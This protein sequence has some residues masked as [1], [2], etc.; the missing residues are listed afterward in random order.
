M[1]CALIGFQT[2]ARALQIKRQQLMQP[3]AGY[4]IPYMV[5]I[6]AGPGNHLCKRRAVQA[7]RPCAQ[8]ALLAGG[9][10]VH[11]VFPAYIPQCKGQ[12]AGFILQRARK[13]IIRVA[14]AQQVHKFRQQQ[15]IR[16]FTLRGHNLR[17]IIG[18]RLIP[19]DGVLIEVGKHLRSL[20]PDLR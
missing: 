1:P 17:Q 4:I 14:V 5:G 18:I 11:A 10:R 6:A 2:V 13:L 19:V 12:I 9:S 16:P 15:M 3:I 7:Q 20:L 8:K